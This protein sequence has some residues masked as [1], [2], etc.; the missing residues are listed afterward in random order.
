MEGINM[1]GEG[2][3]DFLVAAYEINENDWVSTKEIAEKMGIKLSGAYIS[4]G[5]L[6][7]IGLVETEND[8]TKVKL[9]EVGKKIAID[10]SHKHDKIKRFLTDFLC[11]PDAVAEEDAHHMEHV[12]S[13]ESLTKIV[14]FLELVEEFP[15]EFTQWFGRFK[16]MVC[17]LS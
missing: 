10:I 8:N 13:D 17:P 1:L 6:S 7:N 3:E 9:S 15:E 16:R 2:L 14:Y 4:V 12:I 5:K 11:V